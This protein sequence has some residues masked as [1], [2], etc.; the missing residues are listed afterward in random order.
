MVAPD[1]VRS[2]AIGLVAACVGLAVILGLYLVLSG[3]V[4]GNTR[5]IGDLENRPD[6]TVSVPAPAVTVVIMPNTTTPPPG[7]TVVVATVTP[8]RATTTVTTRPPVTTT[9]TQPPTKQPP[10][11]STTS[12]TRRGLPIPPVTLTLPSH[13]P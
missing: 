10:A 11:S 6:P 9:V 8:G 3:E 13:P 1:R 2:L 5:R 12:T 4:G 7:T